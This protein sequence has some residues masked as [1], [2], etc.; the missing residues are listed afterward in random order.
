MVTEQFRKISFIIKANK[1]KCLSKLIIV[2]SIDK[3]KAESQNHIQLIVSDVQFKWIL[4]K[5]GN[6]AN[7]T[8]VKHKFPKHD[9]KLTL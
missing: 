8:F 3:R 9:F 2:Y 6:M 5:D 4:M 7:N 1:Y